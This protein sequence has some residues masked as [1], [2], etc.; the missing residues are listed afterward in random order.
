MEPIPDLAIDLS[1]VI[2]VEATKSLAVIEFD[3]AVGDIQSV[4]RGGESLP[5]VLA[6][7]KVEGGVLWEM[8]PGIR[9][10]RKRIAEARA[11]IHI[12]RRVGMPGKREIAADIE[13]VALIVIKRKE[14]CWGRKIR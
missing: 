7:G 8:V 9:L 1:W 10:S 3:P 12:G 11:V 14:R 13:G 5:E 6:Q 2:P 4:D